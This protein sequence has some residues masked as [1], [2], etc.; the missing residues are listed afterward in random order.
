MKNPIKDNRIVKDM[1]FATR[2]LS[3]AQ[4]VTP[5]DACSEEERDSMIN[6]ATELLKYQIETV[7][8]ANENDYLLRNKC[9]ERIK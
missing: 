2:L 6:Y 1:T 4:S 7:S 8:D 5:H 9:A 3:F